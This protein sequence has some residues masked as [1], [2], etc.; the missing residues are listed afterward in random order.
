IVRS[1]G[2]T[3]QPAPVMQKK[4]GQTSLFSRIFDLAIDRLD[5]NDGVFE[6]NERRVPLDIHAD[7]VSAHMTYTLA[8]KTYDAILSVGKASATLAGKHS[9]S[10]SAEVRLAIKHDSVEIKS[11]KWSTPASGI[12]ASG[13]IIELSDPKLELNYNLTMGMKELGTF[14]SIPEMRSGKLELHADGKFWW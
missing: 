1:D 7:N 9:L 14:I 12:E 8:E 11:L 6:W 4:S 3:N 13:R 2:T 10:S 5:V